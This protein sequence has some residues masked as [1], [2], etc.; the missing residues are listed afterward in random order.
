MTSTAFSE[1]ARNQLAANGD[2]FSALFEHCSDDFVHWKPH[3]DKWSLLEVTC[4]LYDEEREDFR[5]R[6]NHILET[7]SEPMP[8]IHPQ[9]WVTERHYAERDFREVAGLFLSERK[10]SLDWLNNL[11][12][13]KWGNA[14]IHPKVGPLSA[15]MILANWV[16][17]DHLHIRQIIKLKYD[18]LQFVSGEDLN[19]A[20]TW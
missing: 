14:Y 6:V 13:P 10:N 16:A 3:P 15:Q 20:G 18:Y 1:F 5:A 9:Q 12:D 17:H 11:K 8:P 19:Y 4:H 7:P 2:T